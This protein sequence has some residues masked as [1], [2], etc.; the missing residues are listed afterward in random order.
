MLSRLTPMRRRGV[1]ILDDPATP[2]NVRSL[3]MA[4]ITRA[5]AWFGGTTV[6]A[7]ALAAV[8]PHLSHDATLLDVGTGMADIPVAAQAQAAQHGVTLTPFGMDISEHVLRSARDRLGG[9]V[10]GD[11]L[12]LP[13]A[14]DSIDVVTCSQVLHHFV[15]FDVRRVISELHRV[16]RGWVVV[17]D[18]QRSRLAAAGFWI[19]SSALRFH[20]VTRQDGVT[21]VMRGFTVREL[22]MLVLDATGVRPAIRRGAFWRLSAVWSKRPTR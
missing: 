2:G 13:F 21:S 15:D 11:A 7:R 12:R 6:V 9:A 8:F 10:V 14:T 5:N 1:E 20:P 16:S 17:A 3:A 19:A 4:D 22:E 18:L